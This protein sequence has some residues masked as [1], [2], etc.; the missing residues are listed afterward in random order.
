MVFVTDMHFTFLRFPRRLHE[1][2]RFLDFESQTLASGGED[3][4]WFNLRHKQKR[5]HG[6]ADVPHLAFSKPYV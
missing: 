2:S 3:Q 1:Y 5:P 6:D 4:R